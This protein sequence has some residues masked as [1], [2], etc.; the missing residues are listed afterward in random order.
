MMNKSRDFKF[1]AW[2]KI[3]K[4]MVYEDSD[5]DDLDN[6]RTQL[7]NENFSKYRDDQWYPAQEINGIFEYFST[8]SKDNEFIVMQYTGLKDKNGQDICEGDII[9]DGNGNPFTIK[10]DV[11]GWNH[12]YEILKG[13]LRLKDLEIQGNEFEGIKTQGDD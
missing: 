1:R 5:F 4:V 2:D 8:I 13:G 12:I 6:K 11:Y 10:Y 7:T 3:L 9:L